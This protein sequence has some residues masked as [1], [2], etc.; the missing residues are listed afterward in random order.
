MKTR[1]I[2]ILAAMALLASCAKEIQAPEEN[3][4]D[5][6]QVK[7]VLTVGLAATSAFMHGTISLPVPSTLYQP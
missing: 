6:L 2:F 7:T 5:E 4:A 3:P 1:Y